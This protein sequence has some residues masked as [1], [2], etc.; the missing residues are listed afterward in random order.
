METSSRACLVAALKKK[1]AQILELQQQVDELGEAQRMI[2][3][4]TEK[5]LD[6]G[7]KVAL[8]RYLVRC[9]LKLVHCRLM[10]C[11]LL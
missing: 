5:N 4:L 7:E 8:T 3:T 9:L 2:E 6:L 10:N 11:G 1:E